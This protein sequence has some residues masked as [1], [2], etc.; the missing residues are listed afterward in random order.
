VR[1]HPAPGH[2]RRPQSQESRDKAKPIAVLLVSSTDRRS[3]Q[4]FTGERQFTP[5]RKEIIMHRLYAS[6]ALALLLGIAGSA[7]AANSESQ[8]QNQQQSMQSQQAASGQQIAA[9]EQ[10]AQPSQDQQMHDQQMQARGAIDTNNDGR[11]SAEEAQAHVKRTFSALDANGDGKLSQDETS[12]LAA[13]EPGFVV[14]RRVIPVILTANVGQQMWSQMDQNQDQKI[15]RQEY[16][17]Y[18]EQQFNRAQQQAG[19]QMS[20]ANAQTGAQQAQNGQATSPENVIRWREADVDRNGDNIISADEA[21]AA[22]VQIFHQLDRNGDDQLS[23]DELQRVN[24]QKAMIDQRFAKLD[25]NGDGTVSLAE[26]ASAGHD[27]INFADLNQDGEVTAWEYRA[28][29]ATN[30]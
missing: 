8:A 28:V 17:Q 21:A 23:Q 1:P 18:G 27:L 16:M 22:W 30:Q 6:T 13:V 12:G 11:I 20:V 3:R 26:F 25:A 5:I 24:A 29:R 9:Q 14:V 10:Q 19:G 7:D 2:A 15:S 4:A